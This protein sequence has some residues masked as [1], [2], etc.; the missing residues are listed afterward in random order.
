VKDLLEPR[1]VVLSRP[2]HVKESIRLCIG[3][4]A[5]GVT[6]FDDLARYMLISR[7]QAEAL[8]KRI[9]SCQHKV[10]RD[11]VLNGIPRETVVKIPNEQT[12]HCDKCGATIRTVPC[13]YCTPATKGFADEEPA[14]EVED[15]IP[16]PDSVGVVPFQ[17]TDSPPGSEEKKFVMHQRYMSGHPLFHSEDRSHLGLYASQTDTLSVFAFEKDGQSFFLNRCA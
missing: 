3:L 1:R 5:Y 4:M 13:M 7:E 17:Q 12:V 15:E 8:V 2:G 10:I 16:P 14:Q 9:Y 6:Q 11:L